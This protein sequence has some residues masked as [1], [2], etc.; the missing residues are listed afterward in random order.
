MDNHS[1][2]E[3]PSVGAYVGVFGAL[4]VFT[5]ITVGAATLDLGM[6]NTPIAL[7]IAGCKAA[8]VMWIFMELRHAPRLTRLTAITGIAFLAIMLIL[9]FGDYY[10][11][12]LP[13]TPPKAW[14]PQPATAPAPAHAPSQGH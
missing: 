5:A 14:L 3:I 13:D 11:R 2:H 12:T 10:G 8:M 9:T 4:M 6:M 7:A 1:S